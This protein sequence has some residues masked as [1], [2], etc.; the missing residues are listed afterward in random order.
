MREHEKRL[1]RSVHAQVLA[2]AAEPSLDLV[3]DQEDAVLVADAAQALEV[4]LGRRDVAALAEDGL[5]DE[6]GRVAR[7]RLLLEE[8]LELRAGEEGGAESALGSARRC[9]SV[10]RGTQR[11]GGGTYAV[12]GVLDELLV[13]GRVREAELVPV[14]VGRGEDAGLRGA[15]GREGGQLSRSG[16]RFRLS[17][18]RRGSS[19][20]AP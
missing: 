10:G 15:G 14:R 19:R 20:D 18:S 4:A 8:E 13:G 16:R 2:R 12:Q 17:S 6:R 5:D 1:G 7:R 3:D 11:V 9:E